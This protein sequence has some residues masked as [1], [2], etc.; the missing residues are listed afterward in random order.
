MDGPA[1]A[2][3]E[4][5]RDHELRR[6]PLRPDDV[7]VERQLAP[8]AAR[9]HVEIDVQAIARERRMA[10]LQTR[11]IASGVTRVE[12]V[13]IQEC[14]LVA[15]DRP[16]RAVESWNEDRAVATDPRD[17]PV[18]DNAVKRR[19]RCARDALDQFPDDEL[20]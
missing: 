13:E 17:Q 7:S 1:A 18:E 20:L 19:R 14:A 2:A 3:V 8:L 16:E 10:A 12:P 5:D 15:L 4:V 6:D 11:L 9:V